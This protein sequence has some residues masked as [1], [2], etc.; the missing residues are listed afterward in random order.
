LLPRRA[1]SVV[2]AASMPDGTTLFDG[3]IA[4]A[5]AAGPNEVDLASFEAGAGTVRLEMKILDAKGVVIDTDTREIVVPA[6]RKTGPTLYPGAVLRAQTARDFRR[7]SEDVNA[8]PAPRR[9]FRRTERLIIR[10]AAVDPAG[11]PVRVGAALL[12]R[13]RQPMR[14][15]AVMEQTP[16]PGVVQFDLPLAPLAPGEY[17]VRLTAGDA[18]QPVTEFIAFRVGG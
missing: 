15:L 11:N 7:L 4:A 5:G 3:A 2:V 18:A 16:R 13:L 10:V 12:N 9:E 17:S 8:A 6:P 1:A 14:E